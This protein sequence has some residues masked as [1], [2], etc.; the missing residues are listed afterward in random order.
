MPAADV[1]TL[2]N[3]HALCF[4]LLLFFLL[5]GDVLLKTKRSQLPRQVIAR[6]W[7]L[8]LAF[9][10]VITYFVCMLY[11][12]TSLLLV[13]LAYFSIAAV[14]VFSYM[15]IFRA[16][17]VFEAFLR[18]V[19]SP[20]A[21][22]CKRRILSVVRQQVEVVSQRQILFFVKK[23]IVSVMNKAVL[24]IQNNED[25]TWIKFVHVFEVEEEIPDKLRE[26]VRMLDL[27]YPNHRIDL[28]LVQGTFNPETLEALSQH[29][30]LP[31]HQMF[32]ACPNKESP[33][34]VGTL[35]GVRMI[36]H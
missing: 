34:D 1:D 30:N 2:I 20:C 19:L 4:S 7:V 32:I 16:L 29:L 3:V 17:T 8:A 5:V 28:L 35:G 31:K 27:A 12:D 9:L 15:N 11:R 14:L 22:G 36:T 26:H 25:V 33:F 6:K 18:Y 13:F 23:D 24:Y 10:L 21:V